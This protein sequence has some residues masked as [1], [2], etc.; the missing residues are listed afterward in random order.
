MADWEDYYQILDISSEASEEEI[1]K[2]YRLLVQIYHP[3]KYQNTGDKELTKKA[4]ERFKKLQEAYHILGN[5]QKRRAYHSEW[6]KKKNTYTALKPKPEV[7][8]QY[9]RF[10]DVEPGEIKKASFIIKNKEGP[11]AKIWIGNPDSWVK[12]VDWSST[13]PD[14]ELPLKVNIELKG[15][16]WGKS[17]SEYIRVKLDEEEVVVKVELETKAEPVGE[18]TW[19]ED[20]SKV[21]TAPSRSSKVTPRRRSSLL[22]KWLFW[23]FIALM[24][25]A[26]CGRFLGPVVTPMIRA[27]LTDDPS[28]KASY[29][30]RKWIK[31]NLPHRQE[32]T[33]P[34]SGYPHNATM[35]MTS[36]VEHWA[37]VGKHVWAVA[38]YSL[39][40]YRD[41]RFNPRASLFKLFPPTGYILY[42]SNGGEKWEIKKKIPTFLPRCIKFTT[43]TQGYVLGRMGVLYTNDGG[44]HWEFSALPAEIRDM[45]WFESIEGQHLVTK[46][47]YDYGNGWT[48]GL[49]ESFDGGKTWQI[50]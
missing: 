42:S 23:V 2:A 38:S 49:C 32:V 10:R 28:E 21:K 6:L 8:P 5:S 19:T 13:T 30:V 18:Q 17:Y 14:D 11:Y 46:C 29:F 37:V 35:S 25:Y 45:S 50:K 12:V 44:N 27:Y 1:K 3:D 16:D 26:I 39:Y 34:E 47:K 31:Y 7:D 41:T 48:W 43:E 20:I 36:K 24:M 22:R 4:E 40:S 15:E 33:I 9:I